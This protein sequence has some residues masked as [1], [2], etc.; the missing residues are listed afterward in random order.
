MESNARY[1]KSGKADR[2]SK[3][4][5]DMYRDI[6]EK[7]DRANWRRVDLAKVDAKVQN[8]AI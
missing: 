6:V 3:E 8:E 1:S 7:G 2:T 5:G 4:S